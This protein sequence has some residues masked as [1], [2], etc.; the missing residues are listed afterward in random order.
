M[1]VST[2]NCQPNFFVAQAGEMDCA[3]VRR[4]EAIGAMNQMG[5][6]MWYFRWALAVTA[7]NNPEMGDYVYP[8]LD[9]LGQAASFLEGL[10]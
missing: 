10:Q 2:A 4:Y 8:H 6:W 3:W 5:D 7:D 1:R 9:W